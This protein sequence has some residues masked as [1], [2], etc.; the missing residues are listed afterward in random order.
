MEINRK[1][2]KDIYELYEEDILKPNSQYKKKMYIHSKLREDLESRLSETDKQLLDDIC[3]SI[4]D[5]ES[6]IHEKIF[7]KGV[8]IGTQFITEGLQSGVEKE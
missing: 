4:W 3:D 5:L 6:M 8:G 1:I 7:A 2:I